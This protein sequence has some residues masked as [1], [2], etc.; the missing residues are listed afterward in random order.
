MEELIGPDTVNTLPQATLESYRDHGLVR[1]SLEEN[2]DEARDVMAGLEELGI[3]MEEV[4]D[5]LQ[6]DAVR[7]FVEPFDSL[8]QAI[9]DQCVAAPKRA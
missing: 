9:E 6:K 1:P 4:T 3:S 2:V 8:L 5:Q 7:L